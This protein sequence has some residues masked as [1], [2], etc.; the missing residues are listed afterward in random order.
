MSLETN[1]AQGGKVVGGR[2]GRRLEHPDGSQLGRWLSRNEAQLTK[3]GITTELGRAPTL[4]N[5]RG[6]TWISFG[7]RHALGRAVLSPA[8]TCRMTAHRIRD[9][10]P[11]LDRSVDASS[12]GDVDVALSG[13]VACLSPGSGNG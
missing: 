7:S 2:L 1:D 10:A 3:A 6:S 11:C 8:G 5:G 9:G 13:L 4:S 12:R